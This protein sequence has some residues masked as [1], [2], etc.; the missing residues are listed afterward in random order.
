MSPSDIPT[1]ERPKR[2][3]PVKKAADELGLTH[4]TIR[5]YVGRGEVIGYLPEDAGLRGRGL[6]V[7]PEDV[8]RFLA[9]RDEARRQARVSKAL[10]PKKRVP[11]TQ[12]YGDNARIVPLRSGH[13]VALVHHDDDEAAER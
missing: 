9:R 1:P 13:T 3:L 7:D 12:K 8:R 6:M 5:S 10:A 11:W 2:L 4:Q